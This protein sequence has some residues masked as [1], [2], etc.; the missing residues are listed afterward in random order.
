[1]VGKRARLEL[2]L[3][4]RSRLGAL[5]CNVSD[6]EAVRLVG[7]LERTVDDGRPRPALLGVEGRGEA[8]LLREAADALLAEAGLTP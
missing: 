4:A 8:R 6:V 5:R 3:K 7:V 2:L 1:M